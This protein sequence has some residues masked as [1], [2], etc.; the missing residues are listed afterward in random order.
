MKLN[1]MAKLFGIIVD[2]EK[3]CLVFERLNCSVE[4]KALGRG[5]KDGEKFHIIFDIM[6]LL[7]NLHENKLKLGDV[8]PSNVFL[9]DQGDVRMLFPLGI[10]FILIN[11]RKNNSV[12]RRIRGG[13]RSN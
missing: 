7:I 13:R 8:R 11:K 10:F 4:M 9:N 6:D 3:F 2:R 12:Q 1:Y 5:F